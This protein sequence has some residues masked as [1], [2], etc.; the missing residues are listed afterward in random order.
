M[1]LIYLISLF[2]PLFVISQCSVDYSL[3]E[4]R[5]CSS[6]NECVNGYKCDL[7]SRM[8]I[9]SGETT[10]AK[11]IHDAKTS[12]IYKDTYLDYSDIYPADK[13]ILDNYDNDIED[14]VSYDTNDIEEITD[15]GIFDDIYDIKPADVTPDSSSCKAGT[16]SCKDND[17]YQCNENGE[18]I[19]SKNCEIS[20]IND[21][22]SECLTGEKQCK[23]ES[24]LNICSK[25][26]LFEPKQCSYKCY[27]GDCV[28]CL[29]SDKYCNGKTAV[30]CNEIGTQWNEIQCEIGC[31]GGNCMICEPQNQFT[32]NGNDL[33]ICS[34]NGLEYV[35]YK[36]CCHDNNC[37]TDRC[38]ITAPRVL[39]YNPKDW[40]VGSDI[41]FVIDGCFFVKDK[42]IVL[43]DYDGNWK[44]ITSYSNISYASREETQIKINVK[45]RTGKEYN[46]KVR[47]PDGQESDIYPIKKHY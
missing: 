44:E 25:D 22:C 34:A 33:Q 10:D 29:P 5:Y 7:N 24:T 39:D 42:S 47:N 17:L 3:L 38:V 4:N 2:L 40:K 31:S 1:R 11:T 36:N 6:N 12:D 26:G 23:D 13:I 20:C 37:D 14:I 15:N 35:F 16:F 41:Q 8:C 28:I 21:H 18:W 30:T 45:V 19:L 43:I 27:N 9:K 32:C 46:F